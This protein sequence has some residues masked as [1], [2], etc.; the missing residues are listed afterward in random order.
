MPVIAAAQLPPA[1]P[2]QHSYSMLFSPGGASS[3]ASPS[4]NNN[5]H[6]ELEV[7]WDPLEL[8]RELRMA[9]AILG[10][11]CLKLGAKWASEQLNGLAT[12]SNS[13]NNNS[14]ADTSKC[15]QDEVMVMQDRD[16]YAKSLVE[17]GE[18]L[19][20]AAILSEPSEDVMMIQPPLAN[21][22]SFGIYLRAYALYLGGER[23]KEED[24][25]ESQRCV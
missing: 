6:V 14:I 13:Y 15:L 19:H 9:S 8:S 22:S 12:T 20:A 4:M 17:C 10:H 3:L 23:R 21:L 16:W 1:T 5:S 24:H 11:R 25:L 7:H 18:Y 2:S